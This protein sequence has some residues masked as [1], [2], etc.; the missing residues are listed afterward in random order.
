MKSMGSP[1]GS[2]TGAGSAD[3]M[4][5]YFNVILKDLGVP[6]GEMASLLG[7]Q[8]SYYAQLKFLA[9]RLYQRPEFYQDLYDTPTNVERKKVAMQAINSILEREIYKSKMRSEAI[10]SQI[11]ELHVAKRQDDVQDALKNAQLRRQ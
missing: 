4:N 5:D 3:T 11:L 2:G 10:M 6:Q 9:K 7:A 8:P 1:A